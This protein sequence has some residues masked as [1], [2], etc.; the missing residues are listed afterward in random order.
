MTLSIIITGTSSG[1]GTAAARTLAQAGHTVFAA[2]RGVAGKNAEA[3]RELKAAGCRPIEID[4]TSDASVAAG[5]AA[6][7]ETAGRIDV[8]VNCAG[9]MWLGVTEAFSHEQFDTVMQT[10]LYGPF[11]M[12]KAVLPQMRAQGS[13]LVVSITSIAGRLLTPGA[14]IYAASKFALEALAES[15]RYETSLMGIDSVIVEPGPFR[16][17]LK[18]NGVPPADT[19]TAAAYGELRAL[20]QTIPPRMA[21]YLQQNPGQSTD[22]QAFA[23][24]IRDLIAM[25]AGTRPL[26]TTVGYDLGTK[27]INEAVAPHQSAY[28]GVMG[29]ASLEQTHNTTAGGDGR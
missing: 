3:A 18:A 28:L 10:N 6:A 2:M 7:H 4:V 19:A 27:A 13:G 29:L 23:D 11:R 5:V 9:I 16:T 21:A 8:L 12:I 22:P 25:P 15:L 20:E 1:L 14:G 17:N 26:R 24:C